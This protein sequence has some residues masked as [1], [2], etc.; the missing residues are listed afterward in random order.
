MGEASIFLV[1]S[2]LQRGWL[3]YTRSASYAA[4]SRTGGKGGGGGVREE[5]NPVTTACPERWMLKIANK[6]VYISKYL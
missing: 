5:K 2:L 4:A 6:V 3:K 1:I